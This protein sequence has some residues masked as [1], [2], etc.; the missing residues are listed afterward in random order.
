[1]GGG[2]V[3][4]GFALEKCYFFTGRWVEVNASPFS[5]N[6]TYTGGIGMLEFL[7]RARINSSLLHSLKARKKNRCH[8]CLRVELL[9]YMYA[10]APVCVGSGC[11]LKACT[12]TSRERPAV[13]RQAGR[14]AHNSILQAVQ[15]QRG[16]T[17]PGSHCPNNNPS[18]KIGL[19]QKA[20]TIRSH[21]ESQGTN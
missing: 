15:S 17:N 12:H 21:K 2:G 9:G 19:P 16:E 18:S 7:G 4:K 13:S 3:G 11:G 8:C 10:Y 14:Q 5:S 20:L 1:M 6:V